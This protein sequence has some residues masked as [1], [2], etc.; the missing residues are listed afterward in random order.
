[1]QKPKKNILM[2]SMNPNYAIEITNL[3][4]II[5]SWAFTAY[6]SMHLWVHL[7]DTLQTPMSQASVGYLAILLHNL[8]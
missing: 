1:M 5:G 6:T 8:G 4:Q 7:S 2:Q 3:P